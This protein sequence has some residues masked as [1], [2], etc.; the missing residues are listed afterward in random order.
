MATAFVDDRALFAAGRDWDARLS[1]LVARAGRAAAPAAAAASSPEPAPATL[2]G[3]D[4]A[5]GRA[6]GEGADERVSI[7]YLPVQPMGRFIAA[8]LREGHGL[9][10]AEIEAVGPLI[11]SA[12]AGAIVSTTRVRGTRYEL[13]TRVPASALPGMRTIGG[14]L[15]RVGLSPLLN[16]PAI[17][18]LPVP[19]PQVTPRMP[20]PHPENNAATGGPRTL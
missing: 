8:L 16:P 6:L 2:M 1:E 10:P 13:S 14:I 17:P 15:W 9:E 5:F 19:P 20:E 4:P 18:P 11:A 3:G 7:S 12:G